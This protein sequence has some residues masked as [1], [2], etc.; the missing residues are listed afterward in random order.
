MF[1]LMSMLWHIERVTT[2]F[3]GEKERDR[4]T[5]VVDKPMRSTQLILTWLL[6]GWRSDSCSCELNVS[7]WNCVATSRLVD[8]IVNSNFVCSNLGVFLRHMCIDVFCEAT[9]QPNAAFD[10]LK[11]FSF[12]NHCFYFSCFFFSVCAN[13]F[14]KSNERK[15]VEKKQKKERSLETQRT[16]F[17]S[18]S[19]VCVQR[20]WDGLPSKKLIGSY[21]KHIFFF[22]TLTFYD[23]DQP[24]R[25]LSNQDDLFFSFREIL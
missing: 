10:F 17:L 13:V 1:L 20:F 6:S 4:G 25:S 24:M 3:V 8:F 12:S 2:I 16:I 9:Q 19:S 11:P 14:I 5:S 22:M 15:R 7:S 23:D 21:L 18:H